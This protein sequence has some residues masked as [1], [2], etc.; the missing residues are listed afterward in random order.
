MNDMKTTALQRNAL[1]I[2]FSGKAVKVGF[3]TAAML[4][5]AGF[6][7]DVHA[8]SD[9]VELS[10]SLLT[11]SGR[12]EGESRFAFLN[13][14]KLQKAARAKARDAACRELGMVRTPSGWE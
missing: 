12:V 1:A 9:I 5:A 2:L 14:A 8:L 7:S 10:P 11:L 3:E 13:R 4:H 6:I